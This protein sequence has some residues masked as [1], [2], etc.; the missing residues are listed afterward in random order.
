[1]WPESFANAIPY[2]P[3]QHTIPDASTTGNST[4]PLPIVDS[5]QKARELLCSF[6]TPKT[7]LIGHAIDNDLNAT[8]LCHPSII[9]TVLLW[10][11]PKGLPLRFGLKML[12]S[13]YLGR[14]IQTGGDRGHDSLEDAQATGDLVRV[15]I[16]ERW[17]VLQ[18]TG[19]RIKY[20]QLV[21]P[22][23]LQRTETDGK[24]GSGGKEVV[25]DMVAKIFDGQAAG[26]KRRKKR[27]GSGAG[28]STEDEEVPLGNGVAA[29]L[30]YAT[31]REAKDS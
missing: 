20:G 4:S 13:N 24:Q 15:K 25:S 10:P 21:P 12:S 18:S 19:W 22:D 28:E 1:V 29:Y 17:R 3:H 9:D 5:P 7:P 27:A 14:S 23:T 11:H 26:K 6:L 2:S 16:G 30:R 31:G 8:R